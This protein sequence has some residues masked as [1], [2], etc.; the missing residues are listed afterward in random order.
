M[1]E[2]PEHEKKASEDRRLVILAAAAAGLRNFGHY[3]FQFGLQVQ[4]PHNAPY[5]WNPMHDD[6]D[7]L[8]LAAKLR[9]DIEWQDEFV[10]FADGNWSEPIGT[11]PAAAARYA[12]VRAA[13]EIGKA[14]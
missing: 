13:A 12:I 11:D 6:G 3:D 2:R 14:M 1:Y 5:V 8:R 10:V 7:A 4:Q 9:I